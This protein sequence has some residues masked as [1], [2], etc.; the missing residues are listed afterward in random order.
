MIPYLLP[1]ATDFDDLAAVWASGVVLFLWGR[2]LC[3]GHLV[4]EIQILAGWGGACILLTLWGVLGSAPLVWPVAAILVIAAI[5]LVTP[6]LR[7][8]ADDWLA[9]GRVTVLALPLWAIMLTARPSQPDTFLNLLPNSAYLWDHG[10][11]P[12]D[13]RPPIHSLLPAAPYHLQFWAYLAGLPLRH[14]P[15]SAMAHIN[16]LMHLLFGLLLARAVHGARASRSDVPGWG[17]TALG[18]LLATALNPG[19]VPRFDFSSY[20]EASIAVTLGA[21]GWLIARTMSAAAEGQ[22]LPAARWALALLLAALV[23]IKQESVAFVA[24]LAFAVA[25]CGL[26]DRRLRFWRTLRF[27]IPAFLPAAGLYGLWRW[28][29]MT[30]FAEGEL[31]LLPFDQWH[32]DIVPVILGRIIETIAE[33]GVFF[34]FLG[35]AVVVL[36]LRLV[37]R[38]FDQAARLLI[39]LLGVFLVYNGFLLFTYVAHFDLAVGAAAHSYFRYN[40]HLS[41]LMVIALVTV[42]ADEVAR[43]RPSLRWRSVGAALAVLIMLTA[44][45]AFAKFLRFDLDMPQPLIRALGHD[46]AGFLGPGDRLA[47]ILPGDNGSVDTMLEAVLRF[48][49][50]RRPDLDFFTISVLDDGAL[51]VLADKGFDKALVS[52]TDDRPGLWPAGRAAYLERRSGKWRLLAVWRYPEAET[53]RWTGVLAAAPLCHR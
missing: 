52:C 27:F 47:L 33:K 37:L 35:L 20:G 26:A 39:L 44:P 16:V 23:N 36:V 11:L 31:T 34:G 29:A 8:R 24:G 51:P 2:A 3:R 10:V 53:G 30:H 19:F 5:G 45:V 49:P 41:L 43:W 28:F 42:A 21:A 7:P 25:I 14:F 15:A 17:T 13:G 9:L 50:P 1:S 18:L 6:R 40:T 38:G 32:V 12:I 4:P 22:R 48:T 46:V